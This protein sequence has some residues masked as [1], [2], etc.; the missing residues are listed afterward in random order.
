MQGKRV[1]EHWTLLKKEVLKEQEEAVL[2]CHKIS[3]Q[4]SRPA[5][6]NREHF[7]SLQEKEILPPVEEGTASSKKIESC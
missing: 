1:Q 4:E 7:L 6:I 2:L 3:Q 5:W